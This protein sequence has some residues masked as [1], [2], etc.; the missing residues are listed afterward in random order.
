MWIASNPFAPLENHHKPLVVGIYFQENQHSRVSPLPLVDFDQ[1]VSPFSG[2]I[3]TTFG[4]N[5][6]LIVVNIS[7][8]ERGTGVLL[9]LLLHTNT[10][11][12]F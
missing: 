2:W 6:L 1:G 8:T 12:C 7:R 9:S 4:G 11:H 5:T 3:Q 10:G